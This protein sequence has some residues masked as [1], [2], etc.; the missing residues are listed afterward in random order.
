MIALLYGAPWAAREHLVRCRTRPAATS[1]LQK[2]IERHGWDG[3]WYRRAYFDDGTP[4]GS[5]ENDACRIDS[6]AKNW[7]VMAFAVSFLSEHTPEG[8]LEQLVT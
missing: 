8:V 3:D 5:I 7:A 2:N 1:Q 6:I 4:H